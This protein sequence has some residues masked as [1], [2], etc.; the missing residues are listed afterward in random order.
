MQKM[1]MLMAC[2]A[3]MGPAAAFSPATLGV[4]KPSHRQQAPVMSQ[5]ARREL[6]SKVLGAAALLGAASADAKVNYDA[7]AYLGGA[8]QIDVNNANIRVYQKLPGMYPSA[9][10]KLC[11]NGPYVDLKDMYAKAKLSKEEEAIVKEFDKDF[12]FLK[13]QIEYVVDNLNNGLYRR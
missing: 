13:P 11:T 9:A 7:V 6:L 5:V 3:C 10:G 4:S 8:Q 12:L 1:A 2:L